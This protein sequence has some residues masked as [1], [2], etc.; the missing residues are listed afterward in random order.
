[1]PDLLNHMDIFALTSRSE[2]MPNAILEAMAAGLPCVVTDAGDSGKVIH[3]QDTG[4]V[5]PVGDV[6]ALTARVI[7]LAAQPDLRRVMGQR[8][9][10]II[11]QNFD[12]HAMIARYQELYS[13]I[14]ET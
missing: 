9:Q 14:Y 4:Y 5:V 3:H 8:G 1:M 7:E 11:Q 2:G 13:R 12:L 10:A 6:D